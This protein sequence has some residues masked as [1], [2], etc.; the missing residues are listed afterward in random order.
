M[1]MKTL[2]TAVMDSISS[3]NN[4]DDDDFDHS[5]ENCHQHLQAAFQRLNEEILTG[6]GHEI[7]L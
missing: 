7:V 1:R 3:M 2:L 5:T 6:G 4:R